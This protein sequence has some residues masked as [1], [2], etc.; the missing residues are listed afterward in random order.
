[1]IE[2]R[3]RLLAADECAGNDRR[4]HLQGEAHEA[5]AEVDE[6]V[7]VFVELAGSPCAFGEDEKEALVFEQLLAVLR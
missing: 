7:P 1:M 5:G 3:K 4:F 2:L 6:L